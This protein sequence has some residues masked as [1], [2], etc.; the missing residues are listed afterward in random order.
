MHGI[1][2]AKKSGGICPRQKHHEFFTRSSR[3]RD[4]EFTETRLNIL[5]QGV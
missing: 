1:D 4:A 2:Q 5:S 3:V